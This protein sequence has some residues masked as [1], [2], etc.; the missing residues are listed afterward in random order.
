MGDCLVSRISCGVI[1]TY[2]QKKN[3][4]CEQASYCTRAP[5]DLGIHFGH[6][7]KQILPVVLGFTTIRVQ[8]QSKCWHSSYLHVDVTT[9]K[10]ELGAPALGPLTENNKHENG[11]KCCKSFESTLFDSRRVDS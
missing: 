7:T 10:Q 1:A 5:F 4:E 8:A 11:S 2:F 9:V 3:V 6:A